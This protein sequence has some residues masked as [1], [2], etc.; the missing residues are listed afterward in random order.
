MSKP[1]R[2]VSIDG[3][4][5]DALISSSESH[6]ADVPDYPCEDGY[7]VHDTI[8]TKPMELSLTL[9]LSNNP[10]TWYNR[11]GNTS[12]R[13][14][15]VE[16]KMRA[17]FAARKKITVLTA[18]DKYKNMCITSVGISKSKENGDGRGIDITLKQVSITATQT[19]SVPAS[20]GKSGESMCNA[21]NAGTRSTASGSAA[22]ESTASESSSSGS[23]SSDSSSSQNKA[24]LL[25]NATSG[26]SGLSKFF[27]EG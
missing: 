18:T 14:Q 11:L 24:S 10:V 15:I 9:F 21:G 4:E 2:P 13:V 1:K 12:D 27:K 6:T 17:L 23:S 25:Y 22:S 20:Y 19:T 3:V 16:E 8:I 26:L 7:S 5:F